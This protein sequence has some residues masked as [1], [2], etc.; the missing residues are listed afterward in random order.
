[1]SFPVLPQIHV[2]NMFIDMD[3]EVERFNQEPIGY[4]FSVGGYRNNAN[5]LHL[6]LDLY[7]NTKKKELSWNQYYRMSSGTRFLK[8]RER[9]EYKFMT[10]VFKD[11]QE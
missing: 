8:K 4:L 10:G 7:I 9:I 2:T 1:M 11:I 5:Y 3:I 6:V